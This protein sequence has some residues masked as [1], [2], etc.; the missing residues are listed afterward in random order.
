[1][2]PYLPLDIAFENNGRRDVLTL[3]LLQDE[4]ETILVD[5]G[6]PHFV[7]Y[8]EQA[9]ARHGVPL[10]SVTKLIATHHDMDHI[11]SLA[12]LKRMLPNLEVIA[13]ETEKPYIEGSEK[14]LRVVQAEATLDGLTGQER[15]QAE[16]FISFLN[17]IEP[18]AVDRTVVH[19]ERLPWCG[20]I[21]IVH[22]PGHMPGHISLYL[23]SSKTLIAADAVVVEEGKLNIANPQYA[24]DLEEAVRSVRL[25]LDYEIDRLICYH[26]G[27]YEGD[28]KQALLDLIQKY[29]EEG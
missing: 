15:A 16:G 3:T 7:E 8:L 29:S 2:N 13:H 4:R 10:R 24:L 18:T 20:G 27:V 25:L 26:G 19:G 22:T 11:G 12:A 23:P 9:T 6:Y 21:R 1:M 5:C 28:V 14:S 17:A